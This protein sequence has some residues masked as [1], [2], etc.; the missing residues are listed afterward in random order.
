MSR[1]DSE[2]EKGRKE[3]G[4]RLESVES[5]K[6]ITSKGRINTGDGFSRLCFLHFILFFHSLTSFFFWYVLQQLITRGER[7]GWIDLNR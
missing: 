5:D 4:A 3:G 7:D 6:R 1:S 2:I